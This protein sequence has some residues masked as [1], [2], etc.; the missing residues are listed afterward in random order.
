MERL[1]A[2]WRITYLTGEEKIDGCLFCVKFNEIDDEEN[3]IL[4]RGETC[5][6][7][8][9]RYPYTNGHLMVVPVRHVGEV[10]ELTVEEEVEILSLAGRCTRTMK[11]LMHADGFNIGMNLGRVAGAGVADHLHLHIVPRWNGDTNFM[12]VLGET[13]VISEGLRETYNKLKGVF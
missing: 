8:M 12:P 10:S 4:Y 13:R 11:M 6:V 3:L 5:Y 9:N 2:P 1:W 7:I